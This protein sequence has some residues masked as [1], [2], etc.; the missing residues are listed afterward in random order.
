MK[1]HLVCRAQVVLLAALG[2]F[3]GCWPLHPMRI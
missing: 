3:F 1:E 2:V